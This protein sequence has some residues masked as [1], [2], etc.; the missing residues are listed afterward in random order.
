MR[1]LH[2]TETAHTGTHD[3]TAIFKSLSFQIKLFHLKI[4]V[5]VFDAWALI[6]MKQITSF[7][8]NGV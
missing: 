7:Q 6:E 8:N 5:F 2:Q 1:L 4:Q 3:V